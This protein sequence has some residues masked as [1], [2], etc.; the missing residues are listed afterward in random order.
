MSN[1]ITPKARKIWS[2]PVCIDCDG[3]VTDAAAAPGPGVGFDG[4]GSPN[5]YVTS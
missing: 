4:G 2:T 3:R 1:D 5:S